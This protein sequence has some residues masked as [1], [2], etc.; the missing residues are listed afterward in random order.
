MHDSLW[1]DWMNAALG[2]WLFLSPMIGLGELESALAW[3]AYISGVAIALVAVAGI[4][5]PQRFAEGVNLVLGLWVALFAIVTGSGTSA[6]GVYATGNQITVGAIVAVLALLA[7]RA[8][9]PKRI[10]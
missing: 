4:T 3:N 1:Q 9:L 2:V 10:R 8:P 6:E 7:L 5:S